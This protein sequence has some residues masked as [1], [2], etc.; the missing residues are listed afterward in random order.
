MRWPA[1]ELEDLEDVA[2]Q[3]TFETS[4]VNKQQAA[5]RR[6]GKKRFANFK[7]A[8]GLRQSWGRPQPSLPKFSWE[9]TP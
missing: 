1:T 8:G 3:S 4:I 9:D 2:A 5:A 6:N 7:A